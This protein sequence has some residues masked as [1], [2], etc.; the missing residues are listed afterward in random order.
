MSKGN[1][2]FSNLKKSTKITLISCGSFI[3]LSAAILFFFV[4]FPITP[5]EKIISSIGRESISKKED[6]VTT[7]TSTTTTGNDIVVATTTRAT[8]TA[9]RATKTDIPHITSGPGFYTGQKIPSGDYS[10]GGSYYNPTT[11]TSAW[12]YGGGETPTSPTVT[13]GVGDIPAPTEGGGE[14]GG[15]IPDVG[16]GGG[17]VTPPPEV[18][19]EVTGGGDAPVDGGTAE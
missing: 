19:G 9:T 8:T 4:M 13:G 11:T 7:V 10:G 1:G 14:F 5:S 2:F 18:G 17:E 16:N 6:S 3:A 12:G 15:D